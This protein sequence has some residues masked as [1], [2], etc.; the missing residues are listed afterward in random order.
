MLFE[1]HPTRCQ[2]N[3]IFFWL[4]VREKL[5]AFVKRSTLVAPLDD[6]TNVRKELSQYPDNI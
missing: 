3:T 6:V 4:N 5:H 1:P 2:V